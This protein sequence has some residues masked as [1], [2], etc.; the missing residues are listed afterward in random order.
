MKKLSLIC[1]IIAIVFSVGFVA[2]SNATKEPNLY[3]V[4]DMQVNDEGGIFH[5]TVSELQGEQV[6]VFSISAPTYLL[7]YNKETNEYFVN[8]DTFM[9]ADNVQVNF[10]HYAMTIHE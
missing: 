2:H 4:N 10:M 6:K 7:I 1:A 3:L 8:P 9:D 5:G